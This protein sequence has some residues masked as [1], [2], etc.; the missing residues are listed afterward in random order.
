LLRR[1]ATAACLIGLFAGCSQVGWHEAQRVIRANFSNDAAAG[2][3][4]AQTWFGYPPIWVPPPIPQTEISYFDVTGFTQQ[5][6]IHSM[7]T[8]NICVTYGPCATDPAVPT[9]IA[10][11]LEG[12][13]FIPGL[14]CYSPQTAPVPYRVFVLLPRWSPPVVGVPVD[15]VT[16]WN[17]LERSIYIHEKGHADISRQN[18]YDLG[19]QA[20]QLSSCSAVIAFWDNPAIWNKEDADQAAYHARLHADCR[21]EIGCLRAGWLGW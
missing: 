14:Y 6:V 19:V 16:K 2:S 4:I 17:A 15:L 12:I 3:R 11:G 5:Q 8:S 1:L 21:P 18:L 7:N 9:G 13:A 20:S 10:W